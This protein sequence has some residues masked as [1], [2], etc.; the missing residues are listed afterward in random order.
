MD[1]REKRVRLDGDEA[2]QIYT[3]YRR[4]PAVY[5][6]RELLLTSLLSN[7]IEIGKPGGQATITEKFQEIVERY[8][9]PFARDLLDNFFMFGFAP[10]LTV[11]RPVQARVEGTK[12][13]KKRKNLSEMV[14]VPI[15]PVFGTYDIE[16]VVDNE[17]SQQLEFVPRHAVGSSVNPRD[18][19]VSIL[20]NTDGTPSMLDGSHRSLV[21]TL[22]PKYRIMQQLMRGTL[23]ADHVRSQPALITQD[24]PDKARLNDTMDEEPFGDPEDLMAELQEKR[25]RRAATDV[26]VLNEK[27]RLASANNRSASA[28]LDPFAGTGGETL[29]L[30]QSYQNNLF[31]LP[32]GTQVAHQPPLPQIRSDL[33]EMERERTG[34]VCACF[35]IPQSL[36]MSG[37]SRKPGSS[38]GSSDNDVRQL[39]R[40]IGS[41]SATLT[42]ALTE[43]YKSIY[44]DE[45]VVIT[46]PIAPLTT[47]E[48]LIMIYQQGIISKE[49]QGKHLLR[50]VGLPETDLE[51]QESVLEAGGPNDGNDQGEA[52]GANTDRPQEQDE[53]KT[54]SGDDSDKS[55]SKPSS[56]ADPK[57]TK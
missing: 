12:R 49:T 43:V 52:R 33:M 14:I 7:G 51:I 30:A 22:L 17:Y 8:W 50:A 9:M 18:E 26:N 42:R 37:Q 25:Y 53:S 19:R 31:H 57:A 56:D 48:N 38:G 54:S 4:D 45:D 13:R 35:G 29:G 46:L 28:M 10:W 24:A 3:L 34:V 1:P 15:V 23:K 44:P 16:M 36:L 2:T 11:G 21:A 47:I 32:D 6:C 40:T 27:R 20:V 55:K 5:V 41:V 39:M